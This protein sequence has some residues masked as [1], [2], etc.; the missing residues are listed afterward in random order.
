MSNS[1]LAV[2]VF[3][4]VLTLTVVIVLIRTRRTQEVPVDR[5]RLRALQAEWRAP[6]ELLSHATPRDVRFSARGRAVLALVGAATVGLA[7]VGGFLIP[8]VQQEQRENALIRE[9]GKPWSGAITGRWA[10]H[11]KSTSYHVAYEYEVGGHRYA[12]QANVPRGSYDRFTVGASAPIHYAPSRPDVSRMDDADNAP[13]WIRLFIFLPAVLF[14]LVPWRFMQRKKLL[15]WGTPVGAIVT[16][17]SPAKGGRAIRY[18]FLDPSGEVVTGSE[19]VAS[20]DAPQPGEVITALFDPDRPRRAGRFPMG[21]VR[22][23]E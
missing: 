7:T 23:V 3:A 14:L 8:G 20:R 13:P 22:L 16:R 18:Q 9:E 5:E 15:A 1:A 17:S 10:T 4:G 6:A 2:L 21:M 19:V 12:S 11:S